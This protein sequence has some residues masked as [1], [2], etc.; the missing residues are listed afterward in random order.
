MAQVADLALSGGTPTGAAAGDT[1]ELASLTDPD[2]GART[3]VDWQGGLPVPELS[4]R[5][6]TYRDVRPGVDLVVE[7]TNTGFEQFVVLEERPAAGA[8]TSFPVTVRVDGAQV[9][10]SA[11]GGLVATE[12][13]RV[14]ATA[15]AP[16]MWDAVAD[17]GRAFPVTAPRP[18]EP[19]AAA[20]LAPMPDWVLSAGHGVSS[21]GRSAVQREQAAAGSGASRV[22]GDPSLDTDARSV[23]VEATVQNAADD[24]AEML[25]DPQRSFLDDPSTVYPVVIDPDWNLNWGFDT[26]VLKG[27]S[28]TRS[29]D[30]QIDVGTYDSG[31]HVAR[32]FITFDTSHFAGATVSAATFELFNFYSWSC[33]ARA[34]QVLDTYPAGPGTV[35]ANQPIWGTT[36]H[37]TINESHG[38]SSS[39]LGDW[40]RGA[41]TD[42]AQWWAGRGVTE[43]YIGVRALSETDNFGW[44]RFYS[45]DNGAY[46]PSIWVTYNYTPATPAAPALSP[47]G[48]TVGG[49][50][51]IS[52]PT[53]MVST[54]VSDVDGG[55]LTARFEIKQNGAVIR[56]ADVQ[57]PSGAVA[58]Y[59]VPSGVL[60]DGGSYEVHVAVFDGQ[61]WTPW[62]ASTFFSLDRSAPGA[63]RVSSGDYPA[64][65]KWH[66]DGGQAGAFTFSM[67]PADASVVAYQWG[68]DQ[69]PLTTQ[70]VN[71][72]NGAAG[73]VSI[74]PA[75]AGRH[76]LQVRTIDRA[77]NSSAQVAKYSFLVGR[78]GVLTP[79]E[80]AK[81][82]RRA[83]LSVGTN[84]ATLTYVKFQWRRG[85]D[86]TTVTDVAAGALTTSAGQPFT[87]GYDPLPAAGGYSTWDAAM[88]LGYA[89]GPVQVR[90][91]L[92]TDAAGSGATNTQWVTITVDPD[93]DGAATTD[94]GPGSVNLLTGDYKVTVT[95][96]DEFGL[97]VLRTTSSRDTDAGYQLQPDQL[98]LT[99]RDGSDASSYVPLYTSVTSSTQQFHQGGSSLKI[100]ATGV[101]TDSAAAPGGDWG[102][103]RLGLVPGATYRISA[104]VYVPAATGLSPVHGAGESV[105][106]F[107]KVGSAPY[108]DP[109]ATGQLTPRPTKVD[110]WQQRT[111]D[112]T[113]PAGATEAFV[114]LYN[115]FSGST[116]KS[117][118]F[119]DLS[120]RRL[121][122]PF[123]LA[124]SMGSADQTAGTAYTKISQPYDDVAAVGFATG[125]DVWFTTGDGATWFPEPG[126]EDLK[127]TRTGTDSWRLT[128]IDGTFTDFSRPAGS[129]GDFTVANTA[130]PAVPGQARYVYT[131]VGG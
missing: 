53:P 11:D 88:T 2:S 108:S 97:S 38:Y 89:G 130:P 48:T 65:E 8:D 34:Y 59:Q 13:G 120:I 50:R 32:A 113:I 105:A 35:W 109:V 15:A 62:S 4:G 99:Q 47:G 54:T 24:A 69:A 131:Q 57:V 129:S 70:Q 83:Q 18:A 128:E 100:T 1:V 66:K 81:V 122:A 27:Y 26:Y 52:T 79:D 94:I 40:S 43:G 121:W 87:T 19:G 46:I 21:K 41:V 112:V 124:W 6:A 127:L 49:V 25:L 33:Q 78:A 95:D 71:V 117:V 17:A 39:C 82:V 37:A 72:S 80:G 85:P 44:K 58:Q 10:Q 101:T 77:G 23:P 20:R 84:D 102:A 56:S 36:V 63:P 3:T 123:G 75:T 45:A 115:G 126:A 90:A 60:A 14:V 74:T 22:V 12:G 91:V 98:S 92:A 16:V 103:L 116:G 29:T 111:V 106:L 5:R 114:R 118:Y 9:S 30:T 28:N 104:W 73:V 125:G 68:L 64:D 55:T 61:V 31:A 107:T 110:T 119:D 86:S 42:V 51:W 76:T 67:S 96:A 7:A 93:A